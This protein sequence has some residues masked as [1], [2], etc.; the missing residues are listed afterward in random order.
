M[1][2]LPETPA[3]N[4]GMHGSSNGTPMDWTGITQMLTALATGAGAALAWKRVFKRRGMPPEQQPVQN[5]ERRSI[6]AELASQRAMLEEQNI[7][8]GRIEGNV[9]RIDHRVRKIEHSVA[10]ADGQLGRS[11]AAGTD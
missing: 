7:S 5:G 9:L 8:I 11:T 2:L 1:I 10:R 4:R 3:G 6:L